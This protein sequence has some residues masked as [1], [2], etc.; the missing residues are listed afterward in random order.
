MQT[1][2]I[3]N[4]SNPMAFCYIAIV[5]SVILGFLWICDY[6]QLICFVQEWIVK[7]SFH[8]NNLPTMYAK[9]L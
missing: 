1:P 9:V 8:V 6:V 5:N 2:K 7:N 4:L 3:T